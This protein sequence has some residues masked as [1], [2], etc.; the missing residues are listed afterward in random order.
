MTIF[1][2][3]NRIT[4]LFIFFPLLGLGQELYFSQE[5]VG[6]PM[7]AVLRQLQKEHSVELSFLPS[8]LTAYSLKHAG[9]YASPSDFFKSEVEPLGFQVKKEKGVFLV[10]QVSSVPFQI[11]ITDITTGQVIPNAH[12]QIQKKMY[13]S[14]DSGWVRGNILTNLPVSVQLHHIAYQQLDTLVQQ[15]EQQT[16]NLQI[17]RA[18]V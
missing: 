16:I 15:P 13:C 4:L 17:G 12:I 7:H 8:Q 14:S 5:Q 1:R 10:R 11:Q 6:T 2:Y 9:S 18:H 3:F